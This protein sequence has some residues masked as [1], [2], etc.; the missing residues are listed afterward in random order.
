MSRAIKR[1]GELLK[2]FEP[3]HGANQNIT[4][5]G[6]PKVVTRKDA[7]EAAGM[8][9]RQAK[10]AVRVANV[11]A[12]DFER[13]QAATEPGQLSPSLVT[14][15]ILRYNLRR[16]KLPLNPRVVSVSSV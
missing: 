13:Q 15:R 11:P 12:E 5:T 14:Y 2:E 10:T 9:E 8:S 7:A 1:S 4:A 6:G 16:Q 3:A